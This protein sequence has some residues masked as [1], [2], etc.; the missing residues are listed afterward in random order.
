MILFLIID[1]RVARIAQ[2]KIKR[3]YKN[4]YKFRRRNYNEKTPIRPM[5]A[6]D[7]NKTERLE[8]AAKN[9][10]SYAKIRENLRF[11]VCEVYVDDSDNLKNI[12]YIENAF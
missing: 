6:V 8:M 9:F 10:V 11:D 1:G 5:E 3:H 2:N 12:N 7:S 4:Y